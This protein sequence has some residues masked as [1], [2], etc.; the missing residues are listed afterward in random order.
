MRYIT[1]LFFIGLA[2]AETPKELPADVQ[3]R[4]LKA[5]LLAEVAANEANRAAQ[6][7]QAELGRCQCVVTFEGGEFQVKLIPPAPVP[8]KKEEKK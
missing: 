6:S 5:R 3:N 2:N 8:Q 4:V 7:Y 1:L